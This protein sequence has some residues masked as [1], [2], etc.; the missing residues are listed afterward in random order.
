[1]SALDAAIIQQLE[2]SDAKICAT[3]HVPGYMV[4]VGPIPSNNN[5]D[6]LGQQYYGQCLQILIESMELCYT[7]GCGMDAVSNPYE[8]ELDIEALDRMDTMARVV[9][10]TKGISGGLLMPNEGRAPAPAE[11]GQGGDRVYLQKQNWPLDILGSDNAK[12]RR[13]SATSERGST[14]TS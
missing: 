9:A 3:L 14:L 10:T 11:A 5:V 7:E 1:M 13:D 6:A 2:W 8:V 12:R 4:G